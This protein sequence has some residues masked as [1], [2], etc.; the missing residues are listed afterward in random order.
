MGWVTLP[1]ECEYLRVIA[2]A[3][4][5][6]YDLYSDFW[7]RWLPPTPAVQASERLAEIIEQAVGDPE[8]DHRANHTYLMQSALSCYA[9]NFLQPYYARCFEGMSEEDLDRVMQS[10]ALKN[11]VQNEGLIGVLTKQMKG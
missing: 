11:C 10:F 7:M 1:P 3:L 8:I 6:K 4:K 5:A 2:P 9:G